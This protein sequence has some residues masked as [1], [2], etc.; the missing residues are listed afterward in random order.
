MQGTSL[1]DRFLIGIADICCF[2]GTL[3]PFLTR[4]IFE[5]QSDAG[6]DQNCTCRHSMN[7]SS[8]QASALRLICEYRTLNRVDSVDWGIFYLHLDVSV[9]SMTAVR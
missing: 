2:A 9:A 1:C 6:C 7:S 4:C 8:Y 5:P 3:W